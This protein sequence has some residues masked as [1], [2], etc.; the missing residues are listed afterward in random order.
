MFRVLPRPWEQPQGKD[1][2]RP[3]AGIH[4]TEI[5]EA[6]EEKPA[7]SQENERQ[8]DLRHHQRTPQPLALPVTRGASTSNLERRGEIRPDGRIGGRQPEDHP[9]EQ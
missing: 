3:E 2:L 5:V 6:L 4:L 8:G 7:A 9:G 1:V